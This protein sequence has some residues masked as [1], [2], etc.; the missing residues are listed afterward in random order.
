MYRKTGDPVLDEKIK[1]SLTY[2]IL[3]GAFFAL[4]MGIGEYY[5]G[6]YIIFLGATSLQIGLFG[7]LPQFLG[8]V[9]QMYAP[10]LMQIIGSRK[11]AVLLPSILRTLF[12]IPVILAW[13]FMD[14]SI[15]T[16]IVCTTFYFGMNFIGAAPWTSWM[17]DLVDEQKRPVY[18]GARNKIAYTLTLIGTIAGGIILEKLNNIT[19]FVIVFTIAAVASFFSI[20]FLSLKKDIPYI[21]NTEEKINLKSFTKRINSTRFGKFTIFNSLFYLAVFVSAPFF[22]AYEI[23]DLGLNYF[24]VMVAL[25]VTMVGKII[26]SKAWGLITEKYGDV[27]VLSLATVLIAITPLYWAFFVKGVIGVYIAN[28]LAGIAWSG[29]ELLSFNFIYDSVGPNQRARCTSYMTFYK[30]VAILVGGLIGTIILAI[31]PKLTITV[32]IISGLLRIASLLF[33]VKEI[34]ELKQVEPI[35]THKMLFRL[36][37]TVPQEG[38]NDILIGMKSTKNKIQLI[39][40]P[41]FKKKKISNPKDI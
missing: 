16:I 41:M 8:A 1:K 35:A 10:R 33:F 3:D 17:G 23:N 32:F 9:I 36:I 15:T 14:Y 5:V 19:G 21:E 26:F 25:A 30:G 11:S 4:M 20:I 39:T 29:Y 22:T 18:F 13:K 7:T 2:S 38:L 12:W 28:L 31:N 6:A 37:S 27:K 40:D 34:K 24:Q